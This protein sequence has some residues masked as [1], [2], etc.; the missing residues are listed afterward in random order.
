MN[1]E[2]LYTAFNETK[3]LKEWSLDQRCFISLKLLKERVR[4]RKNWTFEKKLITKFN[5]PE[6]F[7]AFGEIKSYIEWSE[8]IRCVVPYRNLLER[9]LLGWDMEKALITP[10]LIK[11]EDC[12]GK[13]FGKLEILDIQY[14]YKR[15]RTRVKVKCNCGKS[16]IFFVLLQNVKNG[17]SNC[18]YYCGKNN[19]SKK[20][21]KHGY[22]YNFIYQ[23][24][25]KINDRCFNLSCRQY[26]DYG[27]RGIGICNEWVLEKY[28]GKSNLNSLRNFEKFLKLKS[29]E[30]NIAWNKIC[31]EKFASNLCVYTLDR[32]DNN[33]GY[34]PENCRWAT[35]K[36][37]AMNRRNTTYYR[38]IIQDKEIEIKKLND[39]LNKYRI[40]I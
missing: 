15:G 27:G 6:Y 21:T 3:T 24:L 8:D 19:K 11:A 2:K 32:I 36:E 37:Q 30:Q 39:E 20:L 1:Q 33:K 16:K 14:G 40:N 35:K 26:K 13:I 12:I 7:Q 10:L 38:K 18:C 22:G 17:R 31:N 29:K 4:F 5:N 28:G 25:S 34:F 23:K 9:K